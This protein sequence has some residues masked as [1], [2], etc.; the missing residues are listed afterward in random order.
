VWE[1]EGT[2]EFAG[3]FATLSPGQQESLD[4]RISL[5][6]ELGP[7]LGRPTVDRIHG[8][9]HHNMK[10][11]R[12]TRDGVLRVLFMFD[13]RRQVI[14]LLGGDKTGS[15]KTWYEWAVPTADRLYDDYLEELNREGL[16]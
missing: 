16:I 1:I 9:R 5:L 10:E 7:D 8:S 3:W 2:D 11:V 15:W 4:D 6:A 14:L 12:A 13:P